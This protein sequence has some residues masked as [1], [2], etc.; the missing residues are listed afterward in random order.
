[1]KPRAEILG[2]VVDKNGGQVGACVEITEGPCAFPDDDAYVQSV[3][4]TFPQLRYDRAT[5]RIM[6]GERVIEKRGVFRHRRN[7]GV[8]LTLRSVEKEA[9]GSVRGSNSVVYD[10]YLEAPDPGTKSGSAQ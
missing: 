2:F 1:M 3:I 8:K 5:R 10:L 4:F 6:L 7:P 9:K